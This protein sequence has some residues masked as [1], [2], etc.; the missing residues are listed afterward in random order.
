[1]RGE[2]FKLSRTIKSLSLVLVAIA[3][4]AVSVIFS[5]G[6]VFAAGNVTAPDTQ[7][8]LLAQPGPPPVGFSP[9]TASNQELAKYGLP[10]RPTD[11]TQ[12]AAWN[13]AMSHAKTWVSP[14]TPVSINLSSS[15]TLQTTDWREPDWAGYMVKSPAH[16]LGVST[17]ITL[18]NKI[19]AT[20]I[21]EF[22]TG[23]GNYS[24]TDIIQAGIVTGGSFSALAKSALHLIVSPPQIWYQE[25]PHYQNMFLLPNGTRDLKLATG[26]VVYVS[27]T[28]NYEGTTLSYATWVDETT[29]IYTTCNWT[30][31][32]I[33]ALT[34]Q[35]ADYIYEAAGIAS[36]SRPSTFGTA[37]FT[38]NC[39]GYGSWIPFSVYDGYLDQFPNIRV[40]MAYINGP[41]ITTPSAIQSSDHSFTV[42]H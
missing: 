7:P 8:A 37:T 20:G 2:K 4:I 32:A 34:S 35:Y 22:W 3:V 42:T 12:L 29:G 24:G 15:A 41:I 9:L 16:I 19:S 21:E 40:I 13:A 26:D 14:G 33:S 27:V 28:P 23:V 5:G 38:S 18:P 25:W 31:T 11:P 10:V 36:Y 17:V 39:F 1:M 30:T 6:A